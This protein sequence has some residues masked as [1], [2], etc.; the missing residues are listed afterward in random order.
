MSQRQI[1]RLAMQLLYQ[2]DLRGEEDFALILKGLEDEP[3]PK[4]VR[5]QATALTEAAWHHHAL[6]DE[7]ASQLAPHWPTHRQPPVDRAILR[8]AFYEI[9]SN[10]CPTNV[11]INEAVELAKQFSSEQAPAF[12][13]GLLDKMA[14]LHLNPSEERAAISESMASEPSTSASTAPDESL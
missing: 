4:D 6:A 11:A 13:N 9:T 12:I 7:S 8:L 3:D 14:K 10:T 5:S 2:I 1:R